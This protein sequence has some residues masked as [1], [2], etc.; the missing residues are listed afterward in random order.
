MVAPPSHLT[1]IDGVDKVTGAATYAADIDRAGQLWG[2][3]LRSP[4]PH[5]RI[6]ALDVSGAKALTGVHAVLTGGDL[7][8]AFLVGRAMRD[9]PVLAQD[10]VRFA[11]EKV[12]AVAAETRE[13]AEAAL[14]L[15]EV[16]YEEL[17]AV[18]DARVAIQP[19][20]PLVHEPEWVRQH[21]TPTQIVAEYPN[22]VSHALLGAEL[23]EI[24]AGLASAPYVFEHTFHT[25][26]QH[27]AYLE[28]HSC[29]VEVDPHDVAHIWAS[30]KVPFLLLDY[31]REGIG[32]ARAQV[33]I[34]MLPLGGD[35]GGKGSFMDVPL[36]YFLARASK[37]P[38]K[39][40]MSYGEELLAGN[41]RHA[42][43][44]VV[45]SGFAPDGRLVACWLRTYY[46]SGAYAAFKP[47]AAATIGYSHAALGC[48]EIPIWRSEN[49]MIYT[50]TVPGGHMRGPGRA[51]TAY[52]LECH[53][54]LCARE[55]GVD[56]LELRIRN[57][58][59]APRHTT[60]GEPGS[61][62]KAREALRAAGEAIGW[63]SPKPPGVGRGIATV[64]IGNSM[65]DYTAEITVERTGDIVFHTP[66]IEQGSGMLTVFRQMV[67][68]AFGVPEE[69]VRV[70]QQ[71][72]AFT[73][74]TGV[75][76]SRLTRIGGRMIEILCRRL[77]SRLATLVA[78]E[79]GVDAN[80]VVW[81]PGGLR[82]ADGR[83]LSLADAVR[84]TGEDLHELIVYERNPADGVHTFAAMAAEVLVDRETGRVHV[85]KLV[86]AHE[87]G[88]IVSPM[89]HRGQIEG[90][91]MQGYGYAM[92][93]GLEVEDGQVTSLNLHDYKI[94]CMA[95]APELEVVLLPPDLS[96]GITP[97]GEGPNCAISPAIAN[98]IA[99]VIRRQVDIPIR[100]E[101]LLD[102]SV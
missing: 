51:Q 77:T 84:L 18:F 71:V 57:V 96:L 23:S 13:I 8:P 5:A 54:D 47:G 24:E 79:L 93:E 17:P 40:I 20:A 41:P 90:A 60:S 95:D 68:E 14:E 62:P 43:T 55:L 70:A 39:M 50:H 65:G 2:K 92:M 58:P 80:E 82:T 33:E 36:A 46:N 25:P 98:A 78:A 83:W 9:M 52:A 44:I 6:V 49:H 35:F 10:V 73:F 11:G 91:L 42:A 87:V 97:I 102:N 75:G 15:I 21:R 12:A 100:P 45:K 3:A 76:G 59:T 61:V 74:D 48:Y 26:R 94:P 31:L 30:N 7:S 38:V 89:L 28:P 72:Q 19:G 88:R 86:S 16:R 85:R 34:H 32:L 4:Y 69:R 64:E 29:I 101:A 1:R 66:V 99:D 81:E 56:P 53:L 63:S 22:S 37:R 67:A 27:Q